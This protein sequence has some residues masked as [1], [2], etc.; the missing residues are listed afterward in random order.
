MASAL[1]WTPIGGLGEVGKNMMA[2]E[3]DRNIILV[4]SGLMFPES[5]MLGIDCVLPDYSFL[6]DRKDQIKAII[7]THGHEDHIGAIEYLVADLPNVPI[8][9][10]PLT[11][12]LIEVKL[13]EAKLYNAST[14]HTVQTDGTVTVGPFKI[15]Y[16]RMCHSIPDNCGLGIT[17]PAGLVV[18]SGDFKLDQTPVDGK[19]SDFGKL[20]EFANRGVMALF[21]DS[22]NA[23]TPGFTA[24]EREIETAFEHVFRDAPG[25]LIV[26]TF[27]S[28][29]SRVQQVVNT[30]EIYGRKL[31][32]AG[33]TMTDN[34]KMAQKM[35][36]LKI[37]DDM[38][39]KLEEANKM[40]A[41]KVCIMATGSQGEPGAVLGRIA[42]GRHQVIN[43]EPGD[44]F[45][46]SAHPIP[47]NEE[48]IHRI[49]N[50]LFQKGANVIYPPLARV[51]VSGHACQEEQKLLLNLVRPKYFVPIHG[52]LRHLNAH[53]RT[54]LAVG[55]PNDNIIVV[56]NG[57][58]LE[59]KDGKVKKLER[60]KGGYVYVDGNSI[61]EINHT[62][63]RD[64]DML[65]REGFV[66]LVVRR[67]EAGKLEGQ[68]EIITRGFVHVHEQQELL[69]AL[70][71]RVS[72]ALKAVD[73]QAS[74]EKFKQVAIDALGRLINQETK[75]KPAIF[76]V[77]A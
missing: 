17:T 52:E 39:I 6:M 7:I 4:D 47:G 69:D 23:E 30:C 49:V 21:S 75:R 16:F 36:Y 43:A 57:T 74:D 37:P 32:V 76:A 62:V 58:P 65:S 72:D 67:N 10:T 68:P 25:R 56:E 54:A 29:I 64:R 33:T 9:A 70:E 44:T 11:R 8:Y 5:D 12:G 2:F 34:V 28:L 13:K 60:I 59:F 45:V 19:P 48:A 24:S 3:Y 71:K 1:K 50:K 66:F 22:T 26:A 41:D 42:T 51:H 77:V 73:P 40:Q 63:L 27:A 46:L 15:E 61:G 31:A 14:L 20:A 18:H 35:G 53:R 38:L 55:V